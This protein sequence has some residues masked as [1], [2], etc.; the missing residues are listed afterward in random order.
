MA[1]EECDSWTNSWL[2]ERF[3]ANRP[4]QRAVAYRM[5]G[6]VSEADDAVRETWLRVSRAG[7]RSVGNFG[8]WLTTV[9]AQVRLDGLRSGTSR[10]KEPMGMHLPDLTLSRHQDGMDPEQ[11]ALLAEG[12]VTAGRKVP[13]NCRALL[14]AGPAG[15][16]GGGGW[17]APG[18]PGPVCRPDRR[19]RQLTPARRRGGPR[20]GRQG[21][22]DPQAPARLAGVGTSCQGLRTRRHQPL[23]V[24]PSAC[25]P[26]SKYLLAGVRMIDD[27]CRPDCRPQWP[28][29]RPGARPASCCRSW[30][31]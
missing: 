27:R 12:V 20:P 22:G 13:G 11:Q 9:V 4:H 3:E 2:A 16:A 26:A 28:W 18:R 24:R 17:V 25:T 15:P 21:A 1:V 19:A 7:P 8:G 29:S 30:S 10:R 31:C 6:S 14:V 5:L 23:A